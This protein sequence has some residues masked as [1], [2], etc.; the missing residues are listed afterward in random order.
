MA[1]HGFQRRAM[2]V[3]AAVSLLLLAHGCGDGNDPVQNTPPPPDP[4][5]PPAV[6]RTLTVEVGGHG[7]G[8]VTSQ[9]TGIDCRKDGGTCA[10][11]FDDGTQVTL[12]A[13]PDA[14]MEFAGWSGGC[15]GGGACALAMNA[16]RSAGADFS[17]PALVALEIGPAGGELVS[18]DGDLRLVIPAGALSEA[19]VITIETLDPIT[20]PLRYVGTVEA[21]G[22]PPS[23]DVDEPPL[24]A[25]RLGPE[26]IQ[27][28]ELVQAIATLDEPD[29]DVVPWLLSGET[30]D[31]V[32]V[33]DLFLEDDGRLTITS[34]LEHFSTFGVYRRGPMLAA[35][36]LVPPDKSAFPLEGKFAWSLEAELDFDVIHTFQAVHAGR[37]DLIYEQA[38]AAHGWRL[39]TD[40]SFLAWGPPLEGPEEI[41]ETDAEDD[42]PLQV[43]GGAACGEV[44]GIGGRFA[45]LTARVMVRVEKVDKN[46]VTFSDELKERFPA[47]EAS[48]LL[49]CRSPLVFIVV[50]GQLHPSGAVQT[51]RGFGL[52]I[53]P[54]GELRIVTGGRFEVYWGSFGG[55]TVLFNMHGQ[56]GAIPS[57]ENLDEEAARTISEA[58]EAHLTEPGEGLPSV[59]WPAV[60]QALGIDPSK[61][62]GGRVVLDTPADQGG[63]L[64]GFNAEGKLAGSGTFTGQTAGCVNFNITLTGEIEG[65]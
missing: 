46:G 43:D 5:P 13:A 10:A 57:S 61:V 26:G 1:D 64:P 29:S 17:N 6:L 36:F 31:P 11:T 28:D 14:G 34:T 60:L 37:D 56:A 53:G 23:G 41:P 42:S 2:V 25:W 16:D 40:H 49:G 22:D 47:A 52:E 51:S 48:G 27:F 50:L 58:F 15:S 20:V 39:L 24:A 21:V 32:E 9:P 44:E 45:R 63:L 35:R 12:T 59:N 7:S 54:N 55:S 33:T 30:V 19:V 18:V 4:P 8:T 65:S 62:C 3:A 38:V